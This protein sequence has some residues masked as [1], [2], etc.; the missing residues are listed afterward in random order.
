[1][2][3]A[4]RTGLVVIMLLAGTA[5]L[6]WYFLMRRDVP[7]HARCIPKDAIA[8]LTLNLRELALDHASGEHLFPEMADKK[9]FSKE[10][11]PFLKAVET[12]GGSGLAETA[13]VLGF[14]FRDGEE[15]Y[16][17]V[18]ASVKDSTKFGKLLREQLAKQFSIKPFSIIGST[19]IR[20]DTT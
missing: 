1:M 8:V 12:N 18:C 2:K 15:A 4:L 19:M 20:F 3:K 9:T 14:F 13:D 5:M 10:I 11:D 7:K 17:G 6:F 16:W